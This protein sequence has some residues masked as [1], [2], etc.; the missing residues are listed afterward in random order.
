MRKTKMEVLRLLAV[1][2]LFL[3]LLSCYAPGQDARTKLTIHKM[4]VGG[5]II[6]AQWSN[7]DL[8]CWGNRATDFF[9]FLRSPTPPFLRSSTPVTRPEIVARGVK[10]HV[11]WI[12]Q[13]HPGSEPALCTLDAASTVQCRGPELYLARGSSHSGS[14]R[15]PA[16]V[17]GVGGMAT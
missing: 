12:P 10:D 16:P 7:D 5:G 6:C 3:A 15:N 11:Q 1:S 2:S 9:P 17:V 8:H 13:R 14:D 4:S